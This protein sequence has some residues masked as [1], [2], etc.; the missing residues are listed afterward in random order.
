M[1]PG[2]NSNRH[3]TPTNTQ[4]QKVIFCDFWKLRKCCYS[5]LQVGNWCDT[6]HSC[7]CT[8][9][10]K[11]EKSS[12]N[13]HTLPLSYL[14]APMVLLMCV[15]KWSSVFK[16]L[17][18]SHQKPKPHSQEVWK[19]KWIWKAAF[20]VAGLDTSSF[21]QVVK[22]PFTSL[23]TAFQ[24]QK[25]APWNC[26]KHDWKSLEDLVFEFSGSFSTVFPSSWIHWGL[27]KRP[28]ST[29][30]GV[31]SLCSMCRNS[32]SYLGNFRPSKKHVGILIVF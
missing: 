15:L 25:E 18:L 3:V 20:P 12:E 5:H 11:N 1:R 31:E 27:N 28:V 10:Q 4:C 23:W 29:C 2:I 16:L 22:E 30:S 24:P 7:N 21:K 13:T 14:R 19:A 26:A 6:I 17:N 32:C 9:I 8:Y